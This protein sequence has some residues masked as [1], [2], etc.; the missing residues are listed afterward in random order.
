ML[1]AELER[2][3]VGD[4]QTLLPLVLCHGQGTGIDSLVSA[5]DQNYLGN[6]HGVEFKGAV[7]HVQFKTVTDMVIRIFFRIGFILF[8]D[9]LSNDALFVRVNNIV[10]SFGFQTGQ[11][12]TVD[13]G[14]F[15]NS[16]AE[17]ID[18]GNAEV[19]NVTSGLAGALGGIGD[20][21]ETGTAGSIDFLNL[22]LERGEKL[23]GGIGFGGVHYE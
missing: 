4:G 12:L 10:Q 1:E 17:G 16:L 21:D 3:I 20:T 6:R 14:E 15:V 9:R 19:E 5:G 11:A 23:S 22:R 2:A 18:I 8:A 13:G 7:I